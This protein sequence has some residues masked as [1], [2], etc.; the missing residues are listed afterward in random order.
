MDQHDT[1]V[2]LED[3]SSSSKTKSKKRRWREIET[4]KDRFQLRKEL[5]DIDIF[6]EFDLLEYEF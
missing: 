6:G 1:M 2:L 4:I 3:E 5:Q